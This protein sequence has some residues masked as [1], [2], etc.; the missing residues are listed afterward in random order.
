[1]NYILKLKKIK[2]YKKSYIFEYIFNIFLFKQ[3]F[4]KKSNFTIKLGFIKTNNN[5]KIIYIN[6]AL[7]YK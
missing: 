1:M 4:Q 6:K 7:F 5:L 2:I 3:G